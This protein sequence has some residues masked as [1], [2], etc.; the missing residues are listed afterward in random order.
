MFSYTHMTSTER[1][2]WLRHKLDSGDLKGPFVDYYF[3][4]ADDLKDFFLDGRLG[5]IHV[6]HLG[7]CLHEFSV[8]P[9]PKKLACLSGKGCPEY[10]FDSSDAKQRTNLVQLMRRT[11]SALEQ[12]EA[13]ANTPGPHFAESWVEDLRNTRDN[14]EKTLSSAPTGG[15]TLVRPF[16]DQPT[17]FQ[18][19]GE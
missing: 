15:T 11:T 9:C 17:K 12:A 16:V 18:P 10:V 19:L 7:L 3:S 8:R 14:V 1:V 4:L 13:K 5:A 6:T 2:E